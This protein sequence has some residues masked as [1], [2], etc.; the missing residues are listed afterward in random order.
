MTLPARHLVA[1]IAMAFTLG[2]LAGFGL[3]KHRRPATG[4]HDFR[5]PYELAAALHARG[6]RLRYVPEAAP[7]GVFLTETDASAHTLT[8]LHLKKPSSWKGTVYAEL[9]FDAA[10][11]MPDQ[12]LLLGR[13][14][15]KGDPALLKKIRDAL[16]R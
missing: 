5:D 2:A 6:L 11:P 9:L 3:G 1:V 15:L 13:L 10:E 4:P 7:G 12:G 14:F 8:L 16:A